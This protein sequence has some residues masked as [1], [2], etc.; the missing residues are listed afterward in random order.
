MTV[1][2]GFLRSLENHVAI[3][4]A[5]SLEV[6]IRIFHFAAS[7][8][9]LPITVLLENVRGYG[10]DIQQQGGRV[11]HLIRAE[12]TVMFEAQ[13]ESVQSI[14][15]TWAVQPAEFDFFFFGD[16]HGVFP[17]LCQ[18]IAAANRQNPLFIMANGDLTHSGHLDEYHALTD[19]LSTSRVPCFTSLGNHDKRAIGS[20][21]AYRQLL[22]P[23]YYS[24]GVADAQFIV[25]DSS[26]KRGLQKLQYRWLE[27]ELQRAQ[28]KRIFVMLHRPPVCPKYNYLSFSAT[29]NIHRFLTLMAAYQVEMVFSSHIHILTMFRRKQIQYIVSGGG[30]GALWRPANI[31]HYLHVFVKREGVE[32]RIVELPT[33]EGKIGQRLKDAIRF[34]LDFYMHRNKMLKQALL[35]G[36]TLLVNRSVQHRQ[37][38]H[39]MK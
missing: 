15:V 31:H 7:P 11:Y 23:Y 34:N 13:G 37:H 3:I 28:G 22:A 10:V 4:R 38:D 29:T 39:R 33:P 1:Q 9:T 21:R 32:L 2:G 36:T 30:G 26:R 17:N 5:L 14:R 16:V 12:T 24:F 19:L 8:P 20:R 6:T 27:R 25:L 18:I 35:L